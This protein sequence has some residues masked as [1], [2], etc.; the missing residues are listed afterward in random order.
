V[1]SKEKFMPHADV[2]SPRRLVDILRALPSGELE[3]LIARLGIPIVAAKR[4][5]TPSQVARALVSL[6]EVRDPSRLPGA[7]AELLHRIAEARGSLLVQSI[8]IGLEPLVARGIVFARMRGEPPPSSRPGAPSSQTTIELV[9]PH[10]YIVQLRSWEGEDPRGVRALLAQA[11][12]ETVSAIASHYLGRPATPPIA[13]SL[14][15]AWEV[16]SDSGKLTEEIDKLAPVERRLLEALEREGGEVETEELLDLEREPMRLRGATGATPSRRGVGFALERRGLLV[17][18]HPNRHVVPTEV[19]LVVGAAH[20]EA[21]ETRR[22]EIKSFVLDV[23]HAPRRARF[24]DDPIALTMAL[25]L[26]MREPGVEVREGVG[27]PRSLV[28]RLAQ[29]FGR[30]AEAVAL[31]AALSRAIGLWDPSSMSSASPPGSFAL[32]E[33]PRALYVAWWHGGAWDEARPD[34]EV[35]RLAPEARDSSPVGVIREMVL[36][37]LRELGEGRWIPWQA[38]SD[39]VRDDTRTA[40]VARLLRRWGERASVEPPSPVDVARRIALESLP[41]LGAIDVG[42]IEMGQANPDEDESEGRV[43]PTLRLTA[44]GRA[45]LSGKHPTFDPGASKFIDGQ[46]LRLGPQARVAAVLALSPLVEIGKVADHIDLILTP[47]GL[48]RALSAGVEAEV[49]RSRIEAIAPMPESLSQ[50]V[51]QASVVVG[52]GSALQAGGFLWIDDANVRELLRS[53]RQTADLFIDPSPPGGLLLQANVDFERLVRR[54][55]ALGVEVT[56]EGPVVR[57]R[58]TM[59]PPSSAPISVG[60]RSSTRAPRETE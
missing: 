41:A 43:G 15:A 30:D 19:A 49:V 12:F 14:E 34:G 17:P 9:L 52:R 31:L 24:A 16:L 45:L 2:R 42:I 39:Y 51:A 53:R 7:S 21:R 4:I 56:I 58:A 25:A 28:T 5:D 44:R 37:A 6:P 54:C 23:D 46:V 32:H 59:P 57:S 50:I 47:P 35:L 22:A 8:P 33:L 40:G 18:V 26:A 60:R 1:A 11:P 3:S 20:L 55:R 36:D 13:L 29:R 38:V 48:A 27:T 10:A